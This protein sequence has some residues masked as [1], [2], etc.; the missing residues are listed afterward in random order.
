MIRFKFVRS[1][2]STIGFECSGHAGFAQAGQ[3]IVCAAVSSAAYL[4]AN[5]ITDSFNVKAKAQ[6]DE[7]YMLFE[8]LEESA[9]AQKVLDGLEAHIRSLAQDYPRSIKV[10][11]GG[12]TNA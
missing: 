7:G 2:K 8:L 1:G 10:I 11:Y 5:T 9:E 12:N 3:D 6:V 4:A